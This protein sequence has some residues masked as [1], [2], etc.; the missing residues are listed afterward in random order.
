MV[1]SILIMVLPTLV[2]HLSTTVHEIWIPT[3]RNIRS[4]LPSHTPALPA[5]TRIG[6]LSF[7]WSRSAVRTSSRQA[8]EQG[9][10]ERENPQRGERPEPDQGESPERL[11][12]RRWSAGDRGRH[13]PLSRGGFG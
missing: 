7:M 8:L 3:S 10:Q 1:R 5:I 2:A 9:D 12:F 11:W 4:T 13:E 6:T